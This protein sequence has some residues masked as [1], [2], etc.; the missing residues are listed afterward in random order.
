MY[1]VFPFLG[2]FG[3]L[4]L[5]LLLAGF[6]LLLLVSLAMMGLKKLRSGN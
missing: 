4:R 2:K 1:L 5:N 3:N 6:G